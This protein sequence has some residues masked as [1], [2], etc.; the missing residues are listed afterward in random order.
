[1]DHRVL[2]E[3]AKA[4]VPMLWH[5]AEEETAVKHKLGM[6]CHHQACLDSKCP[7]TRQHINKGISCVEE[8][9]DQTD[10]SAR[11]HSHSK[12]E[13]GAHIRVGSSHK[14]QRHWDSRDVQPTANLPGHLDCRTMI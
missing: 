7:T 1:M 3:K 9:G 8:G 5:K 2:L 4:L 10:T 12:Q 6:S 11:S 13:Q 14:E